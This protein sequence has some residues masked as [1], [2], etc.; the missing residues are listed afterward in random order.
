MSKMNNEGGQGERRRW[1]LFSLVAA[2]L[3]VSGCAASSNAFAQPS[4][5]I[6]AAQ[7]QEAVERKFP[8]KYAMNGLLNLELTHPQIQLKP[9]QNQLNTVLVVVAS[10][11][12]LQQRNYHGTLDV[13]FSLRY[14]PSDRTL[15]ATQLQLNGLRMDGLNLSGEQLLQQ[16]GS[17]LAQRSLQE[18]VLYQLSE[19]DLA[20]TNGLGLEP[21]QFTVTP[22]GLAVQLK[23][24]ASL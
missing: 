21:G 18:V 13:D 14:E 3:L 12:L 10:G 15:R 6:P 19:Q 24:K 1:V 20:L 5:T 23:P 17:A 9:E 7:L 16:Y 2:G 22:K 11:P 4:F 8:R